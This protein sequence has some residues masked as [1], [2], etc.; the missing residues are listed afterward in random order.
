MEV[1]C[2]EDD[3]SLGGVLEVFCLEDDLSLGSSAC[4]LEPRLVLRVLLVEGVFPWVLLCL[5]SDMAHDL[6]NRAQ[7][8]KLLANG[9]SSARALVVRRLLTV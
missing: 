2:L 7:W 5:G 8:K 6:G 4:L 3:L 1:F 9:R